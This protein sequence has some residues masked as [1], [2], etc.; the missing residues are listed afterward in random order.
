MK[1]LVREKMLG[2]EKTLDT[3]FELGSATA[4]ECIGLSGM[5]YMIID[6][7]H[8]PFNPRVLWN[9]SVRRS[10]IMSRPLQE[11]RRSAV[12]QF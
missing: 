3:F 11:C 4:A 6:T 1:N 8:G 5:D 2:G 7:E 9:L 10:S 12:L